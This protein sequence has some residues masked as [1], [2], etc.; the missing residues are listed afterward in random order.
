MEK[1]K[2]EGDYMIGTRLSGRA[3]HIQVL[4]QWSG[5]SY[6]C[7]NIIGPLLIHSYFIL[8]T[9]TPPQPSGETFQPRKRT[10]DNGT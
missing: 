2:E 6:W 3:M 9:S 1:E 7:T 5:T 8:S 4:P 10:H